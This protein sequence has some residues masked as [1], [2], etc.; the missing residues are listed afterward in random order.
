MLTATNKAVFTLQKQKKK[1]RPPQEVYLHGCLFKQEAHGHTR[2]RA[3]A[4]G[5]K[6]ILALQGMC[7]A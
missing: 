5:T 2:G 1:K 4:Q 7:E 3:L 6:K